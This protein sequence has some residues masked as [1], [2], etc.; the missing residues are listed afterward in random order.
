MS[1][2]ARC[3]LARLGVII[4]IG[5]AAEPADT[6]AWVPLDPVRPVWNATVEHAMTRGG[7]DDLG[8]TASE[9]LVRD[10]FVEWTSVSCGPELSP[11]WRGLTAERPDGRGAD[12]ASAVGW[13]ERGWRHDGSVVG[14]TTVFVPTGRRIVE[15]DI[16][17]NGEDYTWSERDDERLPTVHAP[18]ILRH[19]VGH[20][21]GLGHSSHRRAVMYYAYAGGAVPLGADDET[22]ICALYPAGGADCTVTGCPSGERCVAGACEPEPMG[23]EMCAPCAAPEECAGEVCIGYPDG[24]SY[25]GS[26]CE[27]RF[28][29]GGDACVDVMG[30]E[31]CVREPAPGVFDCTAP[32]PPEC[33]Y[34]SDCRPA[35]RCEGGR[36]EPRGPGAA[37][38]EPCT[39]VDD[40]ASRLCFDGACAQSCDHVDVDSCPDGFYC[41]GD[42]TGV[43][44]SGLCRPRG[45]GTAE[46]GAACADD[47]DCRSQTCVDGACTEPCAP[48]APGESCPPRYACE[49]ATRPTCG[50]CRLLGDGGMCAR[51]NRGE[52]CDSGGCLEYPDG[53]GYCGSRCESHDDCEGTDTCHGVTG[54][55]TRHCARFAEGEPTCA[56]LIPEC[57]DDLDCRVDQRCAMDGTCVRRPM[58]EGCEDDGEC[59]AGRC[60]D[61]ACA[62]PCDP[63]IDG[64]CGDGLRCARREGACDEGW[65]VAGAGGAGPGAACTGDADCA[66]GLCAGGACRPPCPPDGCGDGRTCRVPDA[67][68]PYC[69]PLA[70]PGDPCAM[71]ADCAAGAC[72]ATDGGPRCAAGPCDEGCPV[73]F[74]CAD[75]TCVLD[76]GG[77]GDACEGDADCASG[78]CRDGA[79][80]RT[81]DS[82]R[83][84]PEGPCGDDGVCASAAEAPDDGCGCATP[85]RGGSG[86]GALW[87]AAWLALSFS[88]R[89]RRGIRRVRRREPAKEDG[90]PG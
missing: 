34:D 35:D 18:T 70:E 90:D 47:G 23:G 2:V 37:L 21:L 61:G 55:E 4:V 3:G 30:T 72:V 66:S 20:F 89:R 17:L 64:A 15:A 25:C 51:C 40:C 29:C 80:T 81:C 59:A 74:A 8:A 63:T 75:G 49:A 85:G 71:D 84:C 44:G 5:V 14:L 77:F 83:P 26:L 32:A 33:R 79:C 43:C 46:M 60:V 24:S 9:R 6:R 53:L 27:D 39:A 31:L 22:G 16:E 41:D 38:G 1:R 88:R 45:A 78:L 86:P 10:A 62:A 36:C 68:C 50:F 82:A 73:G 52:D 42:A 7:S 11:D 57:T 13:V 54:L 67:G 76:A 87:L 28:D 48:A 19:E 58:G 69:A 56:D 65:C 12:G